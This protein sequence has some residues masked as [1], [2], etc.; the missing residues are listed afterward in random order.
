VV[1]V[2]TLQ[3]YA[4]RDYR[5]VKYILPQGGQNHEYHGPPK[6]WQQCNDEQ[7]GEV[8]IKPRPG[9]SNTRSAND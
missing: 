3:A 1:T 6:V 7:N 8:V 4:R 5:P 2:K 9:W